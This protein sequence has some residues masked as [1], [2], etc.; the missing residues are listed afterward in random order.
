MCLIFPTT[1]LSL[2][3]TTSFTTTHPATTLLMRCFGAQAATAGL[4][5]GTSTMTARSF[6]IFAGAMV[7]YI[8]G[9]NAWAILGG[10]RDM[11]TTWIWM[12]FIRNSFFLGGSLWAAKMSEEE[13]RAKRA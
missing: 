8:V 4:L 2:T 3:L 13:G 5:L 1:V 11:F 12:D 10:G 6:A 7:P 9:F